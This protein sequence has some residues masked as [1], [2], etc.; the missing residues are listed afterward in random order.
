M[1]N[2]RQLA[3]SCD[4]LN[5]WIQSKE[6]VCRICSLT[7]NMYIL[8]STHFSLLK[9]LKSGLKVLLNF[10]FLGFMEISINQLHNKNHKF[11]FW[12]FQFCSDKLRHFYFVVYVFLSNIIAKISFWIEIS[13]INFTFTYF[14]VFNFI[15]KR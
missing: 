4:S 12:S 1:T 3:V 9:I 2:F 8:K 10:T 13:L 15:F 11:Y 14:L 7:W 5:I 6:F